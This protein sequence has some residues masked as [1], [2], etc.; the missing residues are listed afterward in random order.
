MSLPALRLRERMTAALA[1]A[2]PGWLA[3]HLDARV[4]FEVGATEFG[5]TFAD[6]VARL[7]DR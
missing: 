5:V 7:D 3:S 2:G 1:D 6:G 4:R